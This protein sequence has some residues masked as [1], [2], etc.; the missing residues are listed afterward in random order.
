MSRWIIIALLLVSLMGG[1]GW[2]IVRKDNQIKALVESNAVLQSNNITLKSALQTSNESFDEM[3]RL[4]KLNQERFQQ[5]LTD[6]REIR[7]DSRSI[8]DEIE[9]FDF[10]LSESQDVE[11]LQ[12]NINS[13]TKNNT[14]CLE[15]LTGDSLTDVE[16]NAKTSLEFNTQCPWLFKNE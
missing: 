2:Y 10:T 15:L 14:R 11:L 5:A 3:Q 8:R 9:S 4:N 16:K 13:M 1:A 7:K 12:K 6:L